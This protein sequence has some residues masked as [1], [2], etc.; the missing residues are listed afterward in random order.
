[1]T[2]RL[3][4]REE[5]FEKNEVREDG[6]SP[7]LSAPAMPLPPPL[8]PPYVAA[9]LRGRFWPLWN[10]ERLGTLRGNGPVVKR[11]APDA[12]PVGVAAPDEPPVAPAPPLAA[13]PP[14]KTIQLL[15]YSLL[16]N[17]QLNSNTLKQPNTI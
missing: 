2:H 13:R 14:L 1:M 17:P 5:S 12:E 11:F 8:G 15:N 3:E 6:P 16:N 10:V 7:E 9:W 4:K